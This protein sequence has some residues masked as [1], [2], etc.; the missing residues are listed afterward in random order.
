MTL[1]MKVVVPLDRVG[2]QQISRNLPLTLNNV[3]L[4]LRQGFNAKREQLRAFLHMNWAMTVLVGQTPPSANDNL[5]AWATG[6]VYGF[7]EPARYK[8]PEV[9]KLVGGE[10]FSADPEADDSGIVSEMRF[11][12]ARRFQPQTSAVGPFV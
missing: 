9:V 4:A 7:C 12:G 8:G 3:P 6:T 5:S 2:D 10:W 1:T 11:E